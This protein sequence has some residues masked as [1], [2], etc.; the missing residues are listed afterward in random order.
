MVFSNIQIHP[1]WY[2]IP[3][4]RCQDVEDSLADGQPIPGF[5]LEGRLA[6]HDDVPPA[7]PD[8]A[9]LSIVYN[10]FTNAKTYI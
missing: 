5:L 7:V 6:F 3:F 9:E 1:W 10:F 4:A 2:A 8:I